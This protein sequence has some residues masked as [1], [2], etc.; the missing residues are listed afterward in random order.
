M[1][2]KLLLGDGHA[3][4]QRVLDE[5]APDGEITVSYTNDLGAHWVIGNGGQA[6]EQVP[7]A[8][9]FQSGHVEDKQWI[10]VNHYRGPRFRTTSTPP[11]T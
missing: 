5:P 1:V 7:N 3:A 10:A 11:G 4:L 6:L 8:I 2:E 9:S